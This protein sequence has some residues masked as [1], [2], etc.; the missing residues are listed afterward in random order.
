MPCDVAMH[1]PCSWIVCFERNNNIASRWKKYDITAGRVVGDKGE[2]IWV[3]WVIVLGQNGEIMSM[4]MN[5][6]S[7]CTRVGVIRD[8]QVDLDVIVR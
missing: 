1:E 4:K 6:M 7:L 3:V 5:R 8:S 2:I